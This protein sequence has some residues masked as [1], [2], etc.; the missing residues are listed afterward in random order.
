LIRVDIPDFGRLELEHLVLDYNGTLA[1]DGG[2]L[3]GVAERLT[4]LDARISI[5]VVTAD[6]FGKVR[7]AL[8]GLPVAIHVLPEQAQ[9]RAKRDFVSRLGA[10]RTV[11]IG[12]GRNDRLMLA[13]AALGI[14]VVQREGAAAS[15]LMAADVVTTTIDDALDLLSNPLRLVAS[16]RS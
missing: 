12:N 3:P 10:D 14:A 6:T 11:S 9:E 4:E 5:H 13:E 2:L 1:V 8:S 15:A 7:E 16:L